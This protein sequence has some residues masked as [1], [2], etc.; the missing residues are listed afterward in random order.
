MLEAFNQ[1]LEMRE[2]ELPRLQEGEVLIRVEAAGVCGSDVHMLRGEDPRTGCVEYRNFADCATKLRS[3]YDRYKREM[4]QRCHNFS[5]L[6]K[7]ADN[8]V[9]SKKTDLPNISSGETAGLVRRMAPRLQVLAHSEIP[10]THTI[11]IGPIL[12]GASA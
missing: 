6:E 5:D 9:I 2:F 12:K 7:L 11:R 8:E 3:K 10:E 1:P 4:D